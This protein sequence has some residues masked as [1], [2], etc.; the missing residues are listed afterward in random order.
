MFYFY[1]AI[2]YDVGIF[3]T[4]FFM[5]LSYFYSIFYDIIFL[6][7]FLWRWQIFTVFFMTL[8]YFYSILY[9]VGIFLQ[10]FY[11]VVIFLQYLIRLWQICTVSLQYFYSIFYDVGI[12]LQYYF[13]WRWHIFTVF[14]MTLTYF[15]TVFCWPRHVLRWAGAWRGSAADDEGVRRRHSVHRPRSERRNSRHLR[16]LW[17]EAGGLVLRIHDILVWIS[18]DPDSRIYAS[19]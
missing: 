19:D 12:L 6:Q 13:L 4:L 3:F 15:V 1:S 18:P 5:T 7:Y 11:D 2:F 17:G 10:F 16:D 8:S 9:N 14:F